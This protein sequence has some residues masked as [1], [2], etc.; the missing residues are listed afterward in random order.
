MPWAGIIVAVCVFMCGCAYH[1]CVRKKRN[2][3]CGRQKKKDGLACENVYIWACVCMCVMLWFERLYERLRLR[4]MDE[5][6][7]HHFLF[8]G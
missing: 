4:V 1:L 7:K 5:M 3:G 6:R 2:R 8:A